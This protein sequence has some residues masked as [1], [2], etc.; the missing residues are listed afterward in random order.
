MRSKYMHV[1]VSVAVAA[2]SLAAMSA[3]AQDSSMPSKADTT[4]R[5]FPPSDVGSDPSTELPYAATV[6]R[7]A[8]AQGQ[9]G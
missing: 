2:S 1:L 3:H 4:V 8:Y 9:A 5:A 7:P 6:G